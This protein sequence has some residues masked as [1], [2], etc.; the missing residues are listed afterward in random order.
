V[1][2]PRSG[3]FQDQARLG[4]FV[5]LRGS[6]GPLVPVVPVRGRRWGTA[7]GRCVAMACP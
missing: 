4:L 3:G 5:L 1:D 2:R 7:G 6:F